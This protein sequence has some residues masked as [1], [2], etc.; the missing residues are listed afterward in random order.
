MDGVDAYIL[1]DI[2]SFSTCYSTIYLN[3][4]CTR[5]D[6]KTAAAFR[7][8]R[9]LYNNS[10]FN[11]L[12]PWTSLEINLRTRCCRRERMILTTSMIKIN[13]FSFF[14]QKNASTERKKYILLPI[15]SYILLWLTHTQT[16]QF[17]FVFLMIILI[18]FSCFYGSGTSFS[19]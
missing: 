7:I 4:R 18:N 16:Q 5:F 11:T 9:K 10:K 1:L 15:I 12:T 17:M 8:M 14:T 2:S 13:N 3:H 6:H 19:L